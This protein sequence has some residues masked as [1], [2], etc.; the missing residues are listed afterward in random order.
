MSLQ[1]NT[2]AYQVSFHRWGI[3]RKIKA[4]ILSSLL[5][6]E[7][8]L[9]ESKM[10]SASK[11]IIQSDEYNKIVSQDGFVARWLAERSV[12]SILK[13]GVYL[14]P[15]AFVDMV[16]EKMESYKFERQEVLVPAFLAVYSDQAYAAR[17]MFYLTTGGSQLFDSLE[18]PTVEKMATL[19]SLETSY[20]SF[21]VPDQL[22]YVSEELFR[23]ERER[24][25]QAWQ[26]AED[27]I[28]TLLVHECAELVDGLQVA[29]KG[30]ND[31]TLKKFR[32][33]NV[34]NLREWSQL[35][36]Q[37]RNVTNNE[38][39]EKVVQDINMSLANVTRDDLKHDRSSLRQFV[40]GALSQAQ[41]ELKG[42]LENQPERLIQFE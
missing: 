16:N 3:E 31:G 17:E 35:F 37:A 15:L 30:L 21:D 19:F 5:P 20:I 25:E 18:Y 6:D 36:L 34:E 22:K 27:A 40:Q 26:S 42:M 12:P 41:V 13:K 33:A 11:K 1:D 23:R 10:L 24:V 28:N 29:L 14:I 39:L 9:V 2:I 7:R 38:E 32:E 4:G 8:N